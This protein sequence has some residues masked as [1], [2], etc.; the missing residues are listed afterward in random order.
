MSSPRV[1]D[2]VLEN[3]KE[4]RVV[5]LRPQD[6]VDVVFVGRDYP[7]RRPARSL[8]VMKS[9]PGKPKTPVFLAAVLTPEAKKQLYRWWSTQP[10]APEPLAINKSSHMTIKFRPSLEEVALTPIG[11]EVI[12]QVTGWAADGKI[13]AVAVEPQGVGCANAV[14]HV[15]FAIK[16]PSVA[17][18]LSND[19]FVTAGVR[20]QQVKGPALKA[21]IGWSDGAEY[22]FELPEGV[23]SNPGPR[24][25]LSAAE[26]DA[27]SQS[28]FALPGRRWPINDKRHA[29]IAMQYM[30]RGFGNASDYPTILNAIAKRYPREDKR[31]AEIWS[32]Y[33]KHFGQ[34]SRM[35]ANP[36]TEIGPLSK[37]GQISYENAPAYYV[38]E[39]YSVVLAGKLTHFEGKWT[40]PPSPISAVS[41]R[42]GDAV[43]EFM[44]QGPN[45]K[46][47]LDPADQRAIF[48]KVNRSEGSPF[49]SL[50]DFRAQSSEFMRRFEDFMDAYQEAAPEL[51]RALRQTLKRSAPLR[52]G[53]IDV[54]QNP[55]GDVYDPAKE[56][57]RAVVQGVYE[58]L[59][60]KKLGLPYNSPFMQANGVRIDSTLDPEEKRKLVSSAYAIATRQG[61]KHGWLEP[62]TQTPTE[63]GRAAA[64]DRMAPQASEHT[65][66]NRQ[67]YERTLG[68]VRKSAYYRVVASEVA[69]SRGRRVTQYQVQP[70]PPKEAGV[71]SYR[72]TQ[73]AAEQDAEKAER[74]RS[75]AP[76]AVRLRTNPDYVGDGRIE[77]ELRYRERADNFARLGP[78]EAA[79]KF[80]ESIKGAREWEQK[81]R[82]EVQDKGWDWERDANQPKVERAR[83]LLKRNLDFNKE[84][85]DLRKADLPYTGWDEVLRTHP[86]L[87][88][89]A[90]LTEQ[91]KLQKENVAL[92]RLIANKN[93][94][95]GSNADFIKA[96]N[97][98]SVF[99]PLYVKEAVK[100]AT[101]GSR[102][103]GLAGSG[104][105]TV[106]SGPAKREFEDALK[107]L[108]QALEKKLGTELSFEGFI[109]MF[110]PPSLVDVMSGESEDKELDLEAVPAEMRGDVRDGKLVLPF[111]QQTIRVRTATKKAVQRA[112]QEK[113]KS[114]NQVNALD[115]LEEARMVKKAVINRQ[116]GFDA[117]TAFW[118]VERVLLLY[119]KKV[120]ENGTVILSQ[121]G[122][123]LKQ[124]YT[125][126]MSAGQT[127]PE[128]LKATD[129]VPFATPVRTRDQDEEPT[130]EVE[131]P[132][133]QTRYVLYIPRTRRSIVKKYRTGR[134]QTLSAK[135]LTERTVVRGPKG[136]GLR[137]E[138]LP[139]DEKRAGRSVPG[140]AQ[141]LV[142]EVLSVYP[143][144][145]LPKFFLV[146]GDSGVGG[147]SK[148][149]ASEEDIAQN[150][151]LRDQAAQGMAE[152]IGTVDEETIGGISLIEHMLQQSRAESQKAKKDVKVFL[153]PEDNWVKY[154][155][156]TNS[157]RKLRQGQWDA[158]AND[159]AGGFVG[160]LRD[161]P[162]YDVFYTLSAPLAYITI[163]CFNTPSALPYVEAKLEDVAN[164]LKLMRPTSFTP[165]SGEGKP[166]QY[167]VVEPVQVGRVAVLNLTPDVARIL[168][169]PD[170][171]PL[172][173]RRELFGALSVTPKEFQITPL[174]L[175]MVGQL[176]TAKEKEREVAALRRRGLDTPFLLTQKIQEQA[177]A[178]AP[179]GMY[180]SRP[181]YAFPSTSA[182]APTTP[183]TSKVSASEL[184][185]F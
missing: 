90:A 128:A 34:P 124:Y 12:L 62:G 79:K 117:N 24:G 54:R 105:S 104:K 65:A 42:F 66:Q 171:R 8:E 57:F 140:Q 172:P 33:A 14:P 71:P 67:D 72:L 166:Y 106:G 50:E 142:Q 95:F 134:A 174:N 19:L 17:P 97:A 125:Y 75:R 59:V 16:D 101:E 53:V 131:K 55:K 162:Q 165:P 183:G 139:T 169:K 100:S 123:P 52:R 48:D 20:R 121:Q 111:M 177:Y 147:E 40:L 136:Q 119:R 6:M 5:A 88:L 132:Q 4:G 103:G 43:E 60:R 135:D 74:F 46:S 143:S 28:A 148:N 63:R 84:L 85:Y 126:T 69:D 170:L 118:D 25:G 179:L 149:Q 182:I 86:P 108:N 146:S 11:Q 138:E 58:S 45:W 176:Q 116:R 185:D 180:G 39:P 31:N 168:Q 70:V 160:G 61:Q 87:S 102:V 115:R 98:W 21:R 153:S 9:N 94:E 73:R 175:L 114:E 127:V 36:G 150:A 37:L 26:R 99:I 107:G 2:R 96:K 56:Q 64:F 156:L 49:A 110:P 18:K 145:I 38:V 181:L 92:T 157:F 155:K 112:P 30:L 15:T 120:D 13:Q 77:G 161:L 47:R 130:F 113:E 41:V 133:L 44:T 184:D 158:D 137:L 91:K 122:F 141:G 35:V 22:H 89:A 93:G 1:G 80:E 159:G 154:H 167:E 29:V 163:Q 152:L 178:T 7:I 129:F 81:L 68:S 10:M 173:S 27:L 151:A 3:G 32:F 78:A 23:Q 76:S 83:A 109:N 164:V 51:Q 82:M 144:M